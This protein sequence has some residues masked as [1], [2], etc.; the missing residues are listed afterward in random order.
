MVDE[1]QVNAV[2][3]QAEDEKERKKEAR[4]ERSLRHDLSL[5]EKKETR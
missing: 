3:N 1:H 5:I 4:K 2:I